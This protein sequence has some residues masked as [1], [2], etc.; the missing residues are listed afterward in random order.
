MLT[1]SPA[2]AEIGNQVLV[3][4]SLRGAAD[5]MSL[6]VP[7]GDPAYYAA[8]PRIAV[9]S[10]SLLERDAMFGLPPHWHR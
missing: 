6:V 10:T 4:L 8:R 2:R 5:G 1:A 3:V 7:H 9:P